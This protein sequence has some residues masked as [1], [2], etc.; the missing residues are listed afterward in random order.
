[1]TNKLSMK[2]ALTLCL[3]FL[4]LL[5]PVAARAGV[6]DIISLLTTITGTLNN[7]IGQVLDGIQTVNTTIRNFEQQAVWPITLI[8]QTRAEVAQVRA[9]F[10]NLAAQVH[11]IEMSSATLVNPKQL[12]TRLRS[13][14]AG[15][16][17]QIS[18]S[19][20]QV[21][22]SLPPPE[23]ATP[24]QRNMMDM[25][26]AL[27]LEALK[28][29]II[30]DQASEQM[31]TVADGLETQ[32]GLSAPGS[33]SFLTTQAQAAALQNQAMLQ[34]L[35]AAELRQEAAKLAHSNTLRKQSADA[36]RNL[37]NGMQQI[38]TR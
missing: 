1:M 13:R 27:A 18:A 11:S 38:L 37:R 6:T 32:A 21:Y 16:L 7:S 22:Q 30:S 33:A 12:E 24:A 36:T 20:T 2:V 19:Y 17:T 9:Q 25:D 31:L 10:S 4:L 5:A 26:D 15:D 29:A 28:T 8:D 34:K 14:Q 23:Q 3:I 35:L